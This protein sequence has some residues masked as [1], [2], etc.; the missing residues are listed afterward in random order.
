MDSGGSLLTGRPYG[1]VAVLW[2]KKLANCV[3]VKQYDD[4]RLLGVE[5]SNANGALKCV[6]PI[7][8]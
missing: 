3:Q 2:N 7:P 1:G 5:C 6:S 4:P 8:M